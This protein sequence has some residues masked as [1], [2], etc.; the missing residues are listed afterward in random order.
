[1]SDS[2]IFTWIFPAFSRRQ[3]LEVKKSPDLGAYLQPYFCVKPKTDVILV[4]T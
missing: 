3:D 1:M 2:H 4:G